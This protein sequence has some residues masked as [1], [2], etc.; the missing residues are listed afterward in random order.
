[1]KL[2]KGQKA[3]LLELEPTL[4]WQTRPYRRTGVIAWALV[5]AGLIQIGGLPNTC[6]LTK[7][8]LEVRKALKPTSSKKKVG[9][10]R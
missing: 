4:E 2:T 8:G 10:N 3:F 9:G 5:D 6:L 7:Q 1:M